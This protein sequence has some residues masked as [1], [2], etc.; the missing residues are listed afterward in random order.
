LFLS[1]FG[2]R[3]Y[4]IDR[5]PLDYSSIRQ[6]QNA[7]I[8]RGLYYET[9]GSIPESKKQ[10]AKLNME[11]M[12]FV[13]EPRIIENIAVI[14]YRIMG[15]EHLW[16]PRVAS[17]V[18]WVAGGYFLY[19]TAI[20]IFSPA[21]SLFSVIFYLFLPFGISASR[22]IQPDSLMVMMMLLSIYGVLKYDGNPTLKNLTVSAITTAVGVLVKPYCVFMIFGAF[23][24][25][26]VLRKGLR[27][28]LFNRDSFIFVL[29]AVIP[30]I[31]YYFYGIITN[32]GFL[33]EHARGSFLPHLIID[34]SFWQGWL[35]MIG[36]VVG[37]I[38]FFF[39][40]LGLL[41]MKKGVPKALIFGLYIGYL[42]FGL[43]ATFQIHTHNYYHMPFIPIIALSLGP[44]SVI[45]VNKY[46]PVLIKRL[47]IFAII[48]I[49]FVIIT[50]AGVITGTLQLKNIL[51]NNKKGLKTVA[52][53]IGINPEFREFLTNDFEKELRTAKEIGEHVN[54]ST[55]TVFLDADF[56]RVIAYYGEFAGL[57]WPTSISLYERRLKGTRVPDIKKDFTSKNITILFQGEFIQYVPDYFI[58]TA[59]DEFDKQTDLKE[60]LKSNFPVLAKSDEYLIFDLRKMSD[61]SSLTEALNKLN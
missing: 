34:P 30:T 1:S 44:I 13:L 50:A 37:Y 15:A 54:H 55:N 22:T 59:F 5:P 39:G 57:P 58:I 18:F 60:Y 21:A 36:N 3:L 16:I 61:N 45:T 25:L 43:S 48:T 46:I 10:I 6:Y 41:I 51:S 11:K 4:H 27:S 26:A 33:R 14:G 56:G 40:I 47:R 2:I 49:F 31:A 28:A 7:H 20:R 19:L 29:I 24:S 9:N 12:G 32:V 35:S 8:I 42:L 52:A 23:F 17:S 53:F 38:A